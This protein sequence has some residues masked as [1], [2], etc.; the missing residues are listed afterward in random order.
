MSWLV[1]ISI[2]LSASKF[3]SG[4]NNISCVVNSGNITSSSSRPILTSLQQTLAL[5]S[6]LSSLKSTMHPSLPHIQWWTWVR[7]GHSRPSGLS[8]EFK[9]LKAHNMCYHRSFARNVS[10]GSLVEDSK[11]VTSLIVSFKTVSHHISSISTSSSTS[12]SPILICLQSRQNSQS[13]QTGLQKSFAIRQILSVFI[14]TVSGR[15]CA[16]RSRLRWEKALSATRHFELSYMTMVDLC[17]SETIRLDLTSDCLLHVCFLSIW[18]HMGRSNVSFFTLH[19]PVR[20]A[21]TPWHVLIKIVQGMGKSPHFSLMQEPLVIFQGSDPVVAMNVVKVKLVAPP[22][23]YSIL[24]LFLFLLLFLLFLLFLPLFLPSFIPSFLPP[25]ISFLSFVFLLIAMMLVTIP[26]IMSRAGC[27]DMERWEVRDQPVFFHLQ[28][29]LECKQLSSTPF[30]FPFPFPSPPL[31]SLLFPSLPCSHTYHAERLSTTA[32]LVVRRTA[33]VSAET[34]C[35][36]VTRMLMM[37]SHSHVPF[38]LLHLDFVIFD[39]VS[40]VYG[41]KQVKML[42]WLRAQ[43][44]FAMFL[45]WQLLLSMKWLHVDKVFWYEVNM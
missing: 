18:S 44:W 22:V 27:C 36:R 2:Q 31:P 8:L 30:P 5:S 9:I 20:L 41:N 42:L 39:E 26:H 29:K 40:Q 38:R 45:M 28:L 14:S 4:R 19:I 6:S 16:V 25:P 7:R 32:K 21:P 17:T 1:N 23:P 43:R 37:S 11:Q 15:A 24:L 3:P 12:T 34:W 35:D 13:R 33:A 10:A